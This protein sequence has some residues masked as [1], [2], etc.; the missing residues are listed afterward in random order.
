M[1]MIAGLILILLFFSN[2]ICLA[3]FLILVVTGLWV[4]LITKIFS[5]KDKESKE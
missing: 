4:G 3:I 5:P 2:M 1:P